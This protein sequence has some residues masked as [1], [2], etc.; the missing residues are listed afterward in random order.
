VGFH[1]GRQ[2]GFTLVE[3]LV[4]IAISGIVMASIVSAIYVGIRT[5]T[6]AQRG[7]DQ[8]NAEQI[9][10]N[11]F[12]ADVQ[13]ACDPALSTPTCPRSPNPS[14]TAGSA[15]GT[16]AQFAMDSLSTATGT[17]AD[18]TVAYVLQGSTLTRV[19]CPYN[20]TSATTSAVLAT[21]VGSVA[22]SD[23]VSGTCSG[24][25]QLAVTVSGTT[26]GAGTPD[27]N[28]TFCARPRA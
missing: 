13:A 21:N 4:S 3:L 12:T 17:A 7:L 23:P 22:V 27:Y 28:L 2:D 16:T 25:V 10:G 11:H 26:L 18:T 24:Q 6:G 8:S 9:I 1:E 14:T 15:C 19:S 5:T 20:G